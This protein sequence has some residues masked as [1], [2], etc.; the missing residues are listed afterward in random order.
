VRAKLANLK[1][2][3]APGPDKIHP[4]VLKSCCDELALPLLI[5]FNKSLWAGVMPFAWK[6]AEVTPIFK[7]G[8]KQMQEITDQFPSQV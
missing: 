7:K 2:S 1:D 6:L 3:S 4:K 8:K 5:I